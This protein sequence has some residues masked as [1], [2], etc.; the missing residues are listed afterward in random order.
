MKPSQIL[1]YTGR[2]AAFALPVGFLWVLLF[3]NRRAA[4]GKWPF[5]CYLAALIQITVIRDWS[6]LFR[7]QKGSHTLSH[8]QLI[9]L[10]TTLGELQNGLWPFCF[11]VIGNMI[12]FFPL[13]ILGPLLFPRLRKCGRLLLLALLLSGAIELGQWCF[14]TGVSDVDDIILNT[15]G[16]ALGWL[17]WSFCKNVSQRRQKGSFL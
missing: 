3:H 13:G 10:R 2:A 5:V 16:A 4:L 6:S 12:W 15:A 17:L 11:H 9:P 8:V 1:L 14:S 7:F